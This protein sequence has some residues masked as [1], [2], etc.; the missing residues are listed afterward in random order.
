MSDSLLRVKTMD[1][2]KHVVLT[3]RYMRKHGVEYAL[4]DQFIRCGTSI[5]ANV[6]EAQ[7]AH[8]KQDFIAKLEISLKECNECLYWLELLLNTDSI[9][10]RTFTALTDEALDIR[11]MLIA[12]VNTTKRNLTPS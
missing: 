5:G 1:F 3:C 7:H 4:S 11:N 8:G 9:T 12:S 10:K 2:A 6:F